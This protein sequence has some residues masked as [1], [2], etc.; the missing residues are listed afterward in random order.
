M[1]IPLVLVVLITVAEILVPASVQLGPLLVVAPT[2][3]ASFAGPR[4]T[5]VVALLALAAQVFIVAA[6]G[7][8]ATVNHEVQ[9][10]TLAVISAFVV[11]F[12]FLRERRHRE[13]TRVRSVSD[14][15]QLVV[16][17]PIPPR[18][19]TLRTASMYIAADPEARIGGDLYA[20]ARTSVS[21]RLIIGDVRGKGL[22]TLND[23]AS[24]LC[25]FR[26][27][28]HRYLCLSTLAAHLEASVSR[29]LAEL[30]AEGQD[31]GESFVT[32][33]LVEVPDE[34]WVVRLT[35]CGHPPPLLLRDGRVGALQAVRPA[36]PLGLGE[37]AGPGYD[38]DTFEFE[39]G[40]L[41]VLYTDGVIEARDRTG[42]FYPL[43]ERLTTWPGGDPE[44]LVRHIRDDL[45][46]HVRGTL[47]DDV[48]VIVAERL[49]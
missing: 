11:A 23:A 27:A 15:A 19:G 34:E 7:G 46:K 14:A 35:D 10:L 36:P 5:T 31:V 33:V 28:A 17:R 3:A 13:L 8:V 48:A 2:I 38:E 30:A 18:I 24:L 42:A 22:M 29:N 4:V 26:E 47:G 44:S 1:A 39:P 6:R 20:A 9:I 32:A 49:A 21:T 37:L 43:G 25:A 12:C 16:L 45:L 40:D 41:L